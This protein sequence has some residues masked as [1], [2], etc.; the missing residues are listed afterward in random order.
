MYEKVIH[1]TPNLFIPPLGATGVSFVKELAHL[2]HSYDDSS[3]YPCMAMKPITVLQQLLLQRPTAG[4]CKS[5]VLI[6]C[7]QRRLT[8]WSDGDI[9]GLL[10]EGSCL[11]KSLS[12]SRQNRGHKSKSTGDYFQDVI[13]H[14][15][16]EDIHRALNSLSLSKSKGVLSL[17][18]QINFG[19]SSKLVRDILSDKHPPNQSPL[20]KS[21]SQASQ[22]P[23]TQ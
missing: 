19:S 3:S 11:Q 16:K 18:D 22:L 5:K 17:D 6:D 10:S 14:V 23:L 1:W 12:H 13:N 9:E 8:L 4:P 7:L 15:K 2:F 20:W 21:F